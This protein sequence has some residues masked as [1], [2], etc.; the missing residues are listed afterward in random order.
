LGVEHLLATELETE[1]GR[2]TGRIVGEPCYRDGKIAHLQ[3]WLAETKCP[4]ETSVFYS[5]S[6]NDLPLMRWTD[7][8]VAVDPDSRLRAEAQ[9]LRD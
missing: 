9:Q 6:I 2:Y 4:F 1:A 5:D 7:Q 3:R 8:A